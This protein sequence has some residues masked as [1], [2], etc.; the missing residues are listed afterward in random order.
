MASTCLQPQAWWDRFRLLFI[1]P[2]FSVVQDLDGV[3]YKCVYK[4]L[5]NTKYIID[6]E[7]LNS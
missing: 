4:I 1:I 5:G 7:L 6:V 2:R 3:Y